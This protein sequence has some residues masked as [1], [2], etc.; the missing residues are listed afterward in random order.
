[1]HGIQE[2]WIINLITKRI[3]VY[4]NPVGDEYL[5]KRSFGL[6]EAFALQA[7]PDVV[8]AW[9]PETIWEVLN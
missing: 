9:L 5:S 3:E 4:T 6:N 7:F 8:R 1:M 2:Y